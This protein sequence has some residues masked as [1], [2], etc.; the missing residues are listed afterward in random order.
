MNSF[1]PTFFSCTGTHLDSSEIIAPQEDSAV[2]ISN[3]TPHRYI[4]SSMLYLNRSGK[5]F[6]FD[7]E[8]EEI[9]WEHHNPDDPVWLDAHI[10]EDGQLIYHNVVDVKSHDPEKSE[11]RTILPSGEIIDSISTPGAHHS[12]VPFEDGFATITTEF[13]QHPTYGKIAGDRITFHSEGPT[14][15][16]LSTFSVLEP[17]PLTTMW[18]FGH[19]DDA[20]DWTHANALRW[21]PEQD[22]FVL[23]L[24]GI[25]A[26]WLFD[27]RGTIKAVLLGLGM[28]AKPYQE[29]LAYQ[30]SP[31]LIYEG[32]SFDMPHG[33]TMDQNGVVWVL[34]NGLGGQT[35]SYA[36]GYAIGN[37]VLTQVAD[38]SARNPNAHSAG[39][40]SVVRDRDGSL[41]I[42]WGIYGQIEK[43]TSDGAESWLLESNIQEVFGFS[44][45]FDTWN[46]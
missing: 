18:D 40:G 9:V 7:Q 44:A 24:P 25:N 38:V 34:S 11:I 2:F 3:D 28:E 45:V 29:G 16:I 21:Y 23:C 1:L 30:E 35:I 46:P 22:R 5:L 19:F 17:A 6:I 8:T 4:L 10:R 20:K 31:Y 12:F 36:Q 13:R 14:T 39:L 27:H 41:I 43:R 33:A 32:A 37:D 42:N 26:I 15:T